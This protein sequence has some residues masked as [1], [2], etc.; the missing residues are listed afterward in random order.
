MERKIGEIFT[1][2]GKTYQVIESIR[3]DGC[4]FNRSVKCST[5]S[6]IRELLGS[7]DSIKRK[8]NINVVFKEI[9]DMEI[10]NNQLTIRFRKE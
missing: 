2:K 3:C 9:K 8:G 1:Y 5:N 4:A 10:K 7:C 6:T